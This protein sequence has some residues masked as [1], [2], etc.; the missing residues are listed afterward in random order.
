M[1]TTLIVTCLLA[2][3]AVVG[4][5]PTTSAN[6]DECERLIDVF[7]QQMTNRDE[8]P[9]DEGEIKMMLD[10]IFGCQG[11]GGAAQ[12]EPVGTRVGAV[13]TM[14]S[15]LVGQ[16]PSYLDGLATTCADGGRQ[17]DDALLLMYVS[18][19]NGYVIKD[20]SV[21]ADVFAQ[22]KIE[23]V[24]PL[25]LY[26]SNMQLPGGSALYGFTSYND[27]TGIL[28]F[29]SQEIVATAANAIPG[30]TVPTNS[31]CAGE[32]FARWDGRFTITMSGGFRDC[33]G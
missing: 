12:Y 31:P 28:R 7:Q 6:T 21:G 16:L 23:K 1:K 11:Q 24:G 5:V 8:G 30:C 19:E 26:D 13:S 32:G 3:A 22:G 10:A 18:F 27:G 17:Y 4:T 14:G 20:G 9:L 25:V 2:G 29:G 33:D 15:T